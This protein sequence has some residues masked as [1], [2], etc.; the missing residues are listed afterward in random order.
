MGRRPELSLAVGSLQLAMDENC[1][2]SAK[3]LKSLGQVP[4]KDGGVA[5]T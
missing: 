5:S 2:L 4:P 1:P 3:T